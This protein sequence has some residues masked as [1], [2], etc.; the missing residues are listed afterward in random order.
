MLSSGHRGFRLIL[1][2]LGGVILVAACIALLGSKLLIAD[3]PLP[4]HVDALVVLQGSIAAERERIAGAA[5][6]LQN[7][8]SDRIL[9]SIPGESYWGQSLRPIASSF[10][11]R[12][13]GAAVASKTDFC[14]TGPE[15]DSTRQEAETVNACIQQRHW[16]AVAIVTSEYHT[17]RAGFLWRRAVRHTTTRVWIEAVADPDFQRQWWRTRRSAKIFCLELSKLAWALVAER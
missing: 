5:L 9:V 14:E 13:Y 17:R 16:N 12:N 10:I 4:S 11:E 2:M 8:V 3:D 7:G 1:W 6:L 15:V